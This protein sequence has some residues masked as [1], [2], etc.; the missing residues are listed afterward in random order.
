[1]KILLSK[2]SWFGIRGTALNLFS[3]YLQNRKHLT[4]VKNEFSGVLGIDIGVPQGSVLGPLFF[5]LFLE[6]FDTCSDSKFIK[7]ADTTIM[8][9][10]NSLPALNAKIQ[11]VF[12]SV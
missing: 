1:H 8:I 2:L 5:L 4:K 11:E 9:R 6:N 10:S 3:S 12:S 7:F